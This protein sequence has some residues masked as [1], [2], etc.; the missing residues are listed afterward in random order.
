M[1]VAICVCPVLVSSMRG[2]SVRSFRHPLSHCVHT[3]ATSTYSVAVE[4]REHGYGALPKV[5]ETLVGY[6]TH[7]SASWWRKTVLPLKLCKVTSGLVGKVYVAA[8]QAGESLY[9]MVTPGHS[10]ELVP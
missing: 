2:Q 1:T 7:S 3:H 8:G 6:L 10:E 4:M 9:T 5:E